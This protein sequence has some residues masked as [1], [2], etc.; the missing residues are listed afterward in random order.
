LRAFVRKAV[1]GQIVISNDS[2]RGLIL[3]GLLILTGDVA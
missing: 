3:L 2:G 1:R